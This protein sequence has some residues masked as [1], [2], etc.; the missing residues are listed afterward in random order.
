MSIEAVKRHVVSPD[1]GP[2]TNEADM[3]GGYDAAKILQDL[4][5]KIGGQTSQILYQA[6]LWC[7]P[8]FFIEQLSRRTKSTIPE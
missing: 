8:L 7:T 6:S 5:I 4:A 1:W 2:Q 3:K